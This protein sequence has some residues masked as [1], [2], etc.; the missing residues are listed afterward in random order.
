[1]TDANLTSQEEQQLRDV[2]AEAPN[3]IR[4]GFC[5]C[6]PAVKNLLEWLS[7]KNIPAVLKLV[8]GVM[9]K[10]GEWIYN[11]LDCEQKATQA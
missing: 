9:L 4:D 5:R 10:V 1:M 6:W 7:G 11:A 8:L 3:N 2:I